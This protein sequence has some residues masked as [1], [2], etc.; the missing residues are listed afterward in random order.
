[1]LLATCTHHTEY[2]PTEGV[3]IA[4]KVG[5]VGEAKFGKSI[6]LH[7]NAASVWSRSSQ[8]LSQW[9]FLLP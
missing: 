6:G 3:V 5:V 9:C 2:E 4:Y 1:M 8:L 7:A